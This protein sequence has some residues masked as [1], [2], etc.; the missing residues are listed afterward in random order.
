MKNRYIGGELLK[1]GDWDSLQILE[2]AWQNV[3]EG[4]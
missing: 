4:V 3:F 1:K 2:K